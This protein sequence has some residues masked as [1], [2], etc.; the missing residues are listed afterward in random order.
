[1]L[2]LLITDYADADLWIRIMSLYYCMRKG[3]EQ[4][5]EWRTTATGDKP[6][7]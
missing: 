4:S 1:M 2:L 6:L 5:K 3:N 7:Q